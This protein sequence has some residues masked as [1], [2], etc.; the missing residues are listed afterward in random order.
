MADA[1]R[2]LTLLLGAVCLWALMLLALAATGLGGRFLPAPDNPTLIPSLPAF[3]LSRSASRLGPIGKYREV[4]ER[5]LTMADRRP[6]PVQAAED[7]SALDVTLTSVMI[8]PKLQLAIFTE[9]QGGATQRVKVGDTV[10]NTGWRLVQLEPRR[11]VLEGPSGQRS[12]DLRVFDGKSGSPPT[13][14][15][16]GPTS[17][18]SGAN[19]QTTAAASSPNPNPPMPPP[20]AG[21]PNQPPTQEQQIEAI[22]R[23]IEARRAQMRAEAAVRDESDKR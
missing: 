2:P 18:P 14:V 5:P 15:S 6:A 11:A 21:S 17:P 22:R 3:T 13:M 16:V 23:R 10:A 7:A 20:T 8:T 4:G 12:L 9:N 1:L 19:V